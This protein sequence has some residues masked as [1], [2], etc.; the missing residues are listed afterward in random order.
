MSVWGVNEESIRFILSLSNKLDKVSE[1]LESSAKQLLNAVKENEHGLG[2]HCD[3]LLSLTQ[4]ISDAAGSEK[5]LRELSMRL[6]LSARIR[7]S[8]RAGSASSNGIVFN[9][10]AGAYQGDFKSIRTI[11][12]SVSFSSL[13]DSV[14]SSYNGYEGVGW[15]GMYSGQTPGTSAGSVFDN[16]LRILPPKT[17]DGAP[18]TYKEFDVYSKVPGQDRDGVRFIRGSDNSVY[19]TSDHYFTFSKI[20]K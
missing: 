14:Q 10:E 20:E 9:P 7:E 2:R 5:T 13:P 15:K 12:T 11:I 19:Y 6:R 1:E 3:E 18:I 8:Y 16:D 17:P 4:D